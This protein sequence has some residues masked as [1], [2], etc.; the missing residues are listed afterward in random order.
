MQT[1]PHALPPLAVILSTAAAKPVEIK[2]A[3][4]WLTEVIALAV[5]VLVIQATVS[6]S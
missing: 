2:T 4:F 1:C 5:S 3:V 6:A